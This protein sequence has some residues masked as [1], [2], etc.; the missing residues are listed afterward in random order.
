M[1]RIWLSLI[2]VI[3]LVAIS[4]LAFA[5]LTDFS[6]KWVNVDPNTRGITKLDI[7]ISGNSATVQAWGKASPADIDWGR[8]N[9]VPFAPNVSTSP[10]ATTRTL[11]AIYDTNFCKRYLIIHSGGSRI[12]VEV[13]TVFTDN[14][15]RSN[16]LEVSVFTRSAN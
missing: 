4:N 1:K 10:A 6:G 13:Y 7:Q 12:S 14:S 2:A 15:N 3:L 11:M 8:I 16:Y 9:A 5:A